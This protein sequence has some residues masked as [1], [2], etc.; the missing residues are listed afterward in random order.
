M[1]VSSIHC[2]SLRGDNDLRWY[3]VHMLC[4]AVMGVLMPLD[5]TEWFIALLS[6]VAAGLLMY[7]VAVHHKFKRVAGGLAV[8]QI[9]L[10]LRFRWPVRNATVWMGVTIYGWELYEIK[11]KDVNERLYDTLF[12]LAIGLLSFS[13]AYLLTS[14]GPAKQMFAYQ[15][16][17]YLFVGGVAGT[18]CGPSA[19]ATASMQIIALLAQVVTAQVTHLQW[20]Q[21]TC[22]LAALNVSYGIALYAKKDL[23]S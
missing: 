19:K 14:G 10:A 16:F 9:F 7:S 20:L 13:L 4:S 3:F 21:A 5:K 22:D 1:S 12:D 8:L 18:L 2:L 17:G 6:G 23:R 11:L 15:Q